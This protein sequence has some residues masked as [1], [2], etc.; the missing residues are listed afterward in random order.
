MGNSS[1]PATAANVVP[2]EAA[3]STP[4]IHP[5]DPLSSSEMRR[6]ATAA[7]SAIPTSPESSTPPRFSYITLHEPEKAELAVWSA[8]CERSSVEAAE[9][10]STD[11]AI[12]APPARIAEAV[13]V[14]PATGLAHQLLVQLSSAP[15]AGM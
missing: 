1:S 3:P 5:L 8:D 2:D 12:V 9:H 6:A 4:T 15:D 13:L 7:R 11:A 14:V 10:S